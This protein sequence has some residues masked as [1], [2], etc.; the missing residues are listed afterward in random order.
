[1]A[2]VR[3]EKFVDGV[4]ETSLK[5]PAFVLVM[6]QTL[7]PDSALNTLAGRGIH[8]HEILDAKAK[9][10][11]YSATFDVREHGIRK[12][13]TVSLNPPRTAS[14]LRGTFRDH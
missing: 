7:L 3:I 10:I 5:V 11:R 2:S 12:Q 8:V 4:F 6:A 9:G 1:M 14:D 13:I